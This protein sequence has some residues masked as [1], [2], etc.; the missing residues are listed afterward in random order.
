VAVLEYGIAV[1]A[2]ASSACSGAD[3]ESQLLSLQL[4][5]RL[6]TGIVHSLDKVEQYKV[7]YLAPCTLLDYNEIP[8]STCL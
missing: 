4:C 6:R 2:V 7:E 3:L 1:R 5:F 8:H